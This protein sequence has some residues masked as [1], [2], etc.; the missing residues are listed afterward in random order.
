MLENWLT[1]AW[2][3]NKPLKVL[4]PIS[5]LYGQI[6]NRQKQRVLSGK[7]PQYHA[8]VPV[9]VIGNITVGG[10]GKTPLIIALVHYLQQTG[11]KVGVIARGYGGH[12]LMPSLVNQDSLPT[13]VGDE[14]C[15]IVQKTHAPMAV[16]PNRQLAIRLLLNHYN[17]DM[18]VCDDGLQH[19]K[20]YR[21][22]EWI[23]VDTKRGFGNGRLLPQGF[24]REPIE[25]LANSTVIYHGNLTNGGVFL[26]SDFAKIYHTTTTNA[27]MC[28]V[29]SSLM[30]YSDYLKNPLDFSDT[31]LTNKLNKKIYGVTGIGYPKRFF[32]TLTQLGF[33]VIECAF[34]DHYDFKA[35]DFS[36]LADLPIIV[37][38]KDMIK[39]KHLAL[40]DS[41]K[42]RLWV[43][44]VQA[45]LSQ[46]VFDKADE[47]VK[48]FIKTSLSNQT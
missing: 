16:A 38:E 2:Q 23:V 20:L 45:K 30:C 11:I 28:L 40:D 35:D 37:T 42:N 31:T 14:P 43:L 12:A 26:N 18:I 8:P 41:I 6:A 33:D 22:D 3:D 46:A 24:L 13:Q 15:L 4:A 1:K 17:L 47:F 5:R 25:R 39:I 36:Q 34:N 48:K 32:E 10:S 27:T 29:P 21:D 9:L 7:T 19:Y 44:V